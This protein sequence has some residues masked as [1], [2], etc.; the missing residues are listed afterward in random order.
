MLI[1]CA[2]Y[3]WQHPVDVTLVHRTGS[4]PYEHMA[5]RA[6]ELAKDRAEYERL[7]DR[8]VS[9]VNSGLPPL[10]NVK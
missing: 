1:R 4:A 3:Q 6:K 7:V 10:T 2:K 9:E 5:E 8:I